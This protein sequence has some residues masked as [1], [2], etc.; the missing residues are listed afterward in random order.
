[1]PI[2]C[3]DAIDRLCDHIGDILPDRDVYLERSGPHFLALSIDWN[4]SDRTA[5]IFL[6]RPFEPY[7]RDD[8][9]PMTNAMTF[10]DPNN[11]LPLHEWIDHLDVDHDQ[12]RSLIRLLL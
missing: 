1:M 2:D 10:W 11:R 6:S 9:P 4:D 7:L 12:A 5:L 8:G 3:P